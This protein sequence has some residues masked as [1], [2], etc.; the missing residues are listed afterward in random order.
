MPTTR[1][2]SLA[3]VL[4][5]SVD[6][7]VRERGKRYHDAGVVRILA[8]DDL[9]VQ[10]LVQGTTEYDIEL[11]YEALDQMLLGS[12]SCPYF[13]DQCD[14]C[15]HIWA[16]LLAC[17]SEGYL[18]AALSADDLDL[19]VDF[20]RFEEPDEDEDSS[21]EDD[22]YDPPIPFMPRSV[23]QRSAVRRSTVR[24]PNPKALWRRQVDSLRYAM[25][26]KTSGDASQWSADR[27]ILYVIDVQ[28]A[29][30]GEGLTVE[31]AYRQPKMDGAWSKPKSQAVDEGII[32][33]LS[34]ATDAQL[35][36]L[37][38]GPTPTSNRGWYNSYYR[39]SSTCY[40]L[41]Q[42]LHETMLSMMC[43]TG[44][45][46][47]RQ[48]RSNELMPIRWDDGPAWELWLEVRPDEPSKGYAI[49][50]M[51]R[52]G[53]EQVP[54]AVPVLLVA[55][56]IVFFE[57]RAARLD[58][59]GAF[60]W[61]SLLREQDRITVPAVEDAELL[62]TLLGLPRL[63]RLQLPESLQFERVQGRPR[64]RL[65]VNTP[66]RGRT[67]RLVGL[68]TFDYEGMIID[69][70]HAPPHVFQ[71]EDCRLIVRDRGAE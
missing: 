61:I 27:Q 9:A 4:T 71:A 6:T 65:R 15:K 53:E 69:G 37:M 46:M 17:D 38:L 20:D 54:L 21:D 5:H 51:L 1:A 29:L 22:R 40:S 23:S 64:P 10:A 3:H 11:S 66:S 55:G 45:C 58:D 12:C 30:E 2:R 44:R 34:D 8:G 49:T 60:A 47:L 48:D 14:I 7:P 56:G 43:G 68:L 41:P 57:D 33:Q 39:V 62:N 70:N 13:R 50:G 63:P 67:H 52:R 42:P 35:L 32:S 26:P 24:E 36:S 31:I 16:T 18:S 19:V 59:A 28:K 25:Q